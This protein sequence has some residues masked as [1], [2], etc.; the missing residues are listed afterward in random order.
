[1]KNILIP[2][3]L[4]SLFVLGA[5]AQP[6]ERGP[7][8]PNFK[9]LVLPHHASSA[10]VHPIHGHPGWHRHGGTFYHGPHYHEGRHCGWTG[11]DYVL[12]PAATVG[13]AIGL[14]AAATG[15]CW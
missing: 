12:W 4:L 7:D 10:C 9:L 5:S 15:C 11:R 1:M 2:I 3:L 13:A 14:T 8:L 6:A